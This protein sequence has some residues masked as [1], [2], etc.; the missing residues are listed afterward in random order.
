MTTTTTTP[1]HAASRDTDFAL[2]RGL[3]WFSLALGAAELLAGRQLARAMGMDEYANLIRAYGAREVATG[4]GVLTRADPT[5]WIWG[6]VGGDAL[7]LA[8]LAVGLDRDNPRRENV[9]YA[10]AAVAAA[11]ALDL[12]CAVRLTR[13]A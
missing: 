9:A 6:R 13:E 3:G 10:I 4:I 2:A 12:F 7:D 5:P 8:T 11:T 1:Q